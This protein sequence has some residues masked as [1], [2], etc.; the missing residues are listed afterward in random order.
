MPNPTP[1]DQLAA[2]ARGLDAWT[3]EQVRTHGRFFRSDAAKHL[4]HLKGNASGK[5]NLSLTDRILEMLEDCVPLGETRQQGM[6]RRS[7]QREPVTLAT[8]VAAAAAATVPSG[9]AATPRGERASRE[10][11][12]LT[13]SQFDGAVAAARLAA[14]CLRGDPDALADVG[15]EHLTWQPERGRRGHGEWALVATVTSYSDTT[16]ERAFR[17][18]HG[19]QAPYDAKHENRD[20]RAKHATG[21]RNLLD[22]AATKGLLYR[23]SGA[24]STT[25]CV[26]HHPDWQPRLDEWIGRWARKGCPNPVAGRPVSATTARKIAGGFRTLALYGTRAGHSSA[27]ETNWARVRASLIE[28]FADG[29]GGL[30]RQHFTWARYAYRMLRTAGAIDAPE[31]PMPEDERVSLVPQRAITRAAR[32]DDFSEW[33]TKSGQ[34]ATGLIEGVFSI[35][36][37]KE[38]ATLAAEQ[39]EERQLPPRAYVNPDLKQELRMAR[40][41][42]DEMF[43]CDPATVEGRLQDIAWQA[44]WCEANA[45]IDWSS[46]DGDEV[47]NP[48]HMQK[49]VEARDK[50]IGRKAGAPDT[51]V[52]K[53]AYGLA[54][55]ASPFF[56]ARA[57]AAA[58]HA[59]AD[60]MMEAARAYREKAA[61]LRTWSGKLKVIAARRRSVKQRNKRDADEITRREVQQL[62]LAWSSDGTSGWHKIGRLRDLLLL[63]AER[64]FARCCSRW[65]QDGTKR[66]PMAEVTT[67]PIPEQIAWIERERGLP[68]EER[69]VHPSLTWAV[70][71]RDAVIVGLLYRIPLR[72]RNVIGMKLGN[73][74]ALHGGRKANQWEGEI[75]CEFTAEEMKS[76]RAFQP[77]YMT[78]RMHSD[79]ALFAA[80]RPDLLQLY[81]MEVGARHEVLRLAAG[82]QLVV[83]AGDEAVAH[84]PGDVVPSDYVFPAVARKSGRSPDAAARLAAGCPMDAE[85]FRERW[86][87]RIAEHA[88]SLGI[89]FGEVS[90]IFGG[91]A[92]HAVR[93]LFGTH[94]CWTDKFPDAIGLESASVML[95]HRETGITRKKYVGITER[96]VEVSAGHS[97]LVVAPGADSAPVPVDLAPLPGDDG[98]LRELLARQ[99]RQNY[100]EYLSGV[101]DRAT[102][103][104]RQARVA[105]IESDVCLARVA[106]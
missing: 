94:H 68:S 75:G 66:V 71:V 51:L 74:R 36:T 42:G 14:E 32:F 18:R 89:D 77:T 35:K 37:W 43:R 93:H 85:T 60:G 59:E 102:Y 50:A 56:E 53:A 63:E 5:A 22:F 49:H 47:C 84:G 100:E 83:G 21:I 44:G 12:D 96:Q 13:K 30:S 73:W 99:R 19:D 23:E 78:A 97:T 17:R 106:A 9:P 61:Q 79:P 33:T 45:S 86:R 67:V 38:W 101:I 20:R 6:T 90:R 81:F 72:E 57:L 40:N 70:L 52:S 48:A 10:I 2:L 25:A 65:N 88:D 34:P 80:A 26:V 41:G 82:Q 28:A 4:A 24:Q 91:A 46:Q 87:D 8:L 104:E 92:P 58:A 7:A 64:E 62:W 103:A 39:L 27:S 54:M 3:L 1:A 11:L 29:R 16:A 69:T 95:H 15:P 31:W 105:E 98:E 55:L 76:D